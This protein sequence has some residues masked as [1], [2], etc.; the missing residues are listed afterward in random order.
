LLNLGVGVSA[1]AQRG[2]CAADITKVNGQT[3]TDLPALWPIVEQALAAVV[4]K[5]VLQR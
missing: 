1:W 5:G 4:A 3:A 2:V